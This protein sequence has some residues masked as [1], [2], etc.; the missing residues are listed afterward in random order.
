MTYDQINGLSPDPALRLRPLR[1]C[2][3]GCGCKILKLEKNLICRL[4]PPSLFTQKLF[5]K[6][7]N[8]YSTNIGSIQCVKYI[9]K[10]DLKRQILKL[11]ETSGPIACFQ[12]FSLHMLLELSLLRNP[13]PQSEHLIGIFSCKTRS[14]RGYHPFHA[15]KFTFRTSRSRANRMNE[16]CESNQAFI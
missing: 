4:S 16:R 14:A 9:G 12:A 2:G 1:L 3:C 8:K 6:F 7:K 15:R 5:W 11:K 13:I 10:S